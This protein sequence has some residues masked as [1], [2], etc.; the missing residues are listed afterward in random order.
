MPSRP[1]G[2]VVWLGGYMFGVTNLLLF[3]SQWLHGVT[4]LCSGGLSACSTLGELFRE[5]RCFCLVVVEPCWLTHTAQF[6]MHEMKRGHLW[7]S[8]ILHT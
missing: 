4:S 5:R 7:Y 6:V 1:L 8:K 2:G 3:D